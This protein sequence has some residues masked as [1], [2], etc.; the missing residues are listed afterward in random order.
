MLKGN[1]T[2]SRID[3]WKDKPVMQIR[4]QDALSRSTFVEAIVTMEDFAMAVTGM[5]HQKIEFEVDGLDKVGR[6]KETMPLEF[7]LRGNTPKH[8]A[9][10]ACPEGWK[11]VL[12]FNSQD[13]KFTRDGEQWARTTAERWVD[14]E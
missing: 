11:P 13:S 8:G 2:I 4:I 7:P 1:I 5:S 14:A 6:L 9:I 10:A 12:Y 3:N